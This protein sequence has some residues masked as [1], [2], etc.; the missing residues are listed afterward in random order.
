MFPTDFDSEFNFERPS[1]PLPEDPPF[2]ILMLGDWSGDAKTPKV[3]ERKSIQIDR[4]NFNE[5]LSEIGAAIELDLYNDQQTIIQLQFE[6][7]E[8][9]HPDQVFRKIS[10]FSD[11]RD[12]RRRLS[13]PDTFDAAAQQVRSWFVSNDNSFDDEEIQSQL[14]DAPPVESNNIL[15]L[16]LEHPRTTTSKKPQTVDNSDLGRLVSKLVKPF[17]VKFDENEQAKLI[18]SVDQ[19]ISQLMRI[20]LHHPKFQALEAAWRGLY[21]LVRRVET[22]SQLRI[23]ILDISQGELTDD[24]K[25]VQ[26]LTESF[27][28]RQ[29]K[30]ENYAILA[31]NYSFSVNVE[32]I[33]ALMRLAKIAFDTD[34]SFLSHLKPEFFGVTDFL[35]IEDLTELS[36]AEDSIESRLWSSLRNIPEANHIGLSPMRILGR[37]PYGENSDAVDDFSFEEFDQSV[38][39]KKILWLNPSFVIGLLL[40]QSYKSSGSQMGMKLFRNLERLP[41]YYYRENNVTKIL[42][43]AEILLTDSFLESLLELGLIPF[44]SIRDSDGIKV[45][46]FQSVSSNNPKLAGCWNLFF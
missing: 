14:D 22:D 35:E 24:L 7:I 26:N 43:I 36:T 19:A 44:I 30:S 10:L 5:V 4:D 40:A 6:D 27:L 2:H 8:D 42:P 20:I 29:V 11:L 45:P 1:S 33:A 3:D 41:V 25:S 12:V 37:L 32:D 13:D 18:H 39:T 21:L 9:F 17:L 38:N 34:S 15:D 28:F 23:F 16:I 31:G 46:R